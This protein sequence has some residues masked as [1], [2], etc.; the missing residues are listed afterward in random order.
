MV[1]FFF[2]G[3]RRLGGFTLGGLSLAAFNRFRSRQLFFVMAAPK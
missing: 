3:L 1:H 2:R